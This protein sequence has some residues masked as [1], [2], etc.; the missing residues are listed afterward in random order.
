MGEQM[1][2][3]VDVN[4]VFAVWR[5][6]A[7]VWIRTWYT[8][9]L[10]SILEPLLYLVGFG[11]GVG[12]F[13]DS[14]E[15]HTYTEYI[16]PGIISAT[17]MFGAFVETTWAAFVRM[18]YQRTWQAIAATPASATDVLVGELVWGVTKS[19]INSMIMFGSILA[20]SLIL[21]NGWI[22]EPSVFLFIIPLAIFGGFFFG[23]LGLMVTAYAKT[24]DMLN[25]PFFLLINPMFILAGVFFPLSQLP[26]ALQA[27]A[28]AL[29]LTHIGILM[30]AGSWGEFMPSHWWS[31]GYLVVGSFVF[32]AVGVRLCLRRIVS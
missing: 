23:G 28:M 3:T 19:V 13:I 9:I 1:E 26:N 25:V 6:H 10:P 30:R 14:M 2:K 7:R 8:N 21:G 31:I 5:R 4:L 24:I 32:S 29:P 22:I 20:M 12:A 16:A 11:L 18:Y 15:G 17:I 27:V